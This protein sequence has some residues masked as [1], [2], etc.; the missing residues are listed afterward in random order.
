MTRLSALDAAPP[1][2]AAGD[3]SL[4][5]PDREIGIPFADQPIGR[6]P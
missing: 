4:G 5:A 3:G 2:D 6:A 1:R